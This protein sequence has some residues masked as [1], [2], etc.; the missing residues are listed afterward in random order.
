MAINSKSKLRDILAD[1]RAVEI[2][3]SYKPGFTQS[4]QLGPVQG[5]RINILLG[6][7]QSGFSKEDK[8]DIL[9]KLDALDA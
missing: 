3:E 5:M 8:A 2:I 4:D 1:E 7:P 9:A 6:F